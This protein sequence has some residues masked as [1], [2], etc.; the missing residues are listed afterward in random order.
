MWNVARRLTR[1]TWKF[2]QVVR[3]NQIDV[4]HVNPSLG[5]KAAL[6]DGLLLMGPPKAS[7]YLACTA[8]T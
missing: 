5:A 4:V 7:S 2:V 3:G 8:V 1:D 6:R